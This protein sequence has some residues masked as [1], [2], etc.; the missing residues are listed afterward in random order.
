MRDR[1]GPTDRLLRASLRGALLASCALPRPATAAA[2]PAGLNVLLIYTDDQGTLD[3][4]SYG[5]TD[6]ETPNIDALAARGVRFTQAYGHTV[7]CPSRA[8]LMT[9]RHPQR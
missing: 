8:T 3:A 9:G 7:C 2:A 4:G 5:S 6:V 1:P